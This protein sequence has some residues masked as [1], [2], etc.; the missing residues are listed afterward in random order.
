MA[1]ELAVAP[2]HVGPKGRVSLPAAVRR[3]AGV[4]EG[5]TVVAHT[6]GPG[7]IVIETESAIRAR[8]WGAAPVPG[9]V[10]ATTDIR[11]LRD[12]DTA[13]A[14]AAAHR[15]SAQVTGKEDVGASLLSHL[16]L[17]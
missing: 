16:G 4:E 13:V 5:A 7:R 17:Q 2:F 3:A 15:R 1:H 12:E 6:D 14:D 11:A 10:D 9:S 8:V